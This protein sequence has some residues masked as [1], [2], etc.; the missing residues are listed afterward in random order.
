MAGGGGRAVEVGGSL[1]LV[2]VGNVALLSL[3]ND[4]LRTRGRR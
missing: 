3:F 4:Y 1:L 2:E